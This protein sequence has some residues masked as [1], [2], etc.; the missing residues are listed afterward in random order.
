MPD[1]TGSSLR[2]VLQEIGTEDISFFAEFLL[3][4]GLGAFSH[5]LTRMHGAG[6]ETA[7]G[8]LAALER[9]RVSPT[10][11]YIAQK[12]ALRK[13]DALFGAWLTLL[14]IQK[15]SATKRCSTEVRSI[16]IYTG[17]FCAR[18]GPASS[19]PDRCWPAV[20]G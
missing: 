16:S 9:E 8:V 7:P 14:Q 5:E 2:E 1:A 20:S 18:V 10:V 12:S 15:I 19:W 13:L 3:D 11:L 6:G 4:Q 17:I